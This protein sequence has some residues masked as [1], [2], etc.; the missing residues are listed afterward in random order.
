MTDTDIMPYGKHKGKPMKEVPQ[1][2]FLYMYDRKLLKGEILKYAEENVPV[3][4]HQAEKKNARE[5]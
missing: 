1:G 5:K 2:W 3:L 4:R